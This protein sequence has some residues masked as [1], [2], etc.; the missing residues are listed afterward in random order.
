MS[1]M[2]KI[3]LTG[4]V[5]FVLLFS[6]QA[7]ATSVREYQ[8]MTTEGKTAFLFKET[9]DLLAKVKAYDPG[10]EAKTRY[11]MLD[12]TNEFGG[13]LGLGAV[14]D[15]IDTSE[16]KR[17]E[18]MDKLQIETVTKIVF[19]NYWQSEGIIVP[20]SVLGLKPAPA[21]TNAAPT[22]TSQP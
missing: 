20:A 2:I 3:L 16:K 22:T 7:W 4:C 8:A 18:T 17:P 12:E 9:N 11:Y 13:A 1:A 14:L 21:S 5:T 10:L 15:V 19:R 6:G